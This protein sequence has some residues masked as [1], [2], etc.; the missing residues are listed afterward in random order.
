MGA[1]GLAALVAAGAGGAM[2]SWTAPQVI[3]GADAD[4]LAL[5]PEL[6]VNASGRALA[7]WDRETGPDCVEAPASLTCIH[8]IETA[9]RATAGAA[10]GSRHAINRPGVGARPRAAINDAGDAVLI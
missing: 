8:T 4:G 6:A 9:Y 5:V 1:A 2:P 7:V 3:S 10:W